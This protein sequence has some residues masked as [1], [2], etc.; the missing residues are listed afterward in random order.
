V[1][2]ELAAAI[3]A[4]TAALPAAYLAESIAGESFETFFE[5][6]AA[7]FWGRQISQSGHLFERATTRKRI[8]L[9]EGKI[10][11]L[12]TLQSTPADSVLEVQARSPRTCVHSVVV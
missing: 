6:R 4:A 8:P 5:Q 2:P 7:F 11:T 10:G 1:T 9:E 3:Q 12:I